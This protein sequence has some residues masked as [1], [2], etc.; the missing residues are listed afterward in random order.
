MHIQ[1]RFLILAPGRKI[2]VNNSS[3]LIFNYKNKH[4]KVTMYKQDYSKEPSSY[5]LQYTYIIT[6][7]RNMTQNQKCHA[8]RVTQN[9]HSR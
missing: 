9:F 5:H 3:C 4:K 6:E 7:K 2:S 8:Q 1:L